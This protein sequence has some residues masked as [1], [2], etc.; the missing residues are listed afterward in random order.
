MNELCEFCIGDL[1]GLVLAE[2]QADEVG[3]KIE[4]DYLVESCMFQDIFKF[5]CKY[6]FGIL[7]VSHSYENISTGHD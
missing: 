7:I 5:I 6:K 1:S 4:R 3:F 2:V